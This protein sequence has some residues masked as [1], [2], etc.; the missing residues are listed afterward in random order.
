MANPGLV[1]NSVE[2]PTMRSDFLQTYC[3]LVRDEGEGY[4]GCV[5]DLPWTFY[6]A[7]LRGGS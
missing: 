2:L 7:C 3:E 6:A 4:A 1:H 5:K